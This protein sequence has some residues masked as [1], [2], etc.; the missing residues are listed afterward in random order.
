MIYH[1]DALETLQTLPSESVHCAVT[2]P[3]YY[4]LRDY[5]IAGQIGREISPDEYVA[6]LVEV[7]AEVRRVL[8]PDGTLWVNIGDSYASRKS[9]DGLK[10][11]DMV[12]I[13]WLLAFALRRDGWYLRQDIVWD[14]PNG[15]PENVADR[16]TKTHEYVFLLSK[17]ATYYFNAK[18][19]EERA[20]QA[21][22]VR[23]DK[24]GGNKGDK[25]HHSPGKVFTGSDTRRCRA[26]WN[27]NTRPL[28]DAHFAPFPIELP[29]RC[30]LAGCPE[31]GTVLDPFFGAGTTGLAALKNG[32][33]FI[34]IE[35]NPEYVAL[36]E[37]RIDG[38]YPL[39][40]P[41]APP[42]PVSALDSL[43]YA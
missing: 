34:G 29:E 23:A 2:S 41:L 40:A 17:S 30:L 7:F 24:M 32:R 20:I 15:M 4:G 28:K 37:A 22:R 19:I 21:G 13:P 27:L 9:S 39:F 18:A 26:V 33:E 42:C 16:C 14:K 36:A 38:E 43:V 10:P 5:G 1:G 35:L 31:G 25:V 3:P 8:R 11:K 6:R 12:G